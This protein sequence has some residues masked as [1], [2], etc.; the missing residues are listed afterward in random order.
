M[1]LP[2]ESSVGRNGAAASG[3]R[4]FWKF[5]VPMNGVEHPRLAPLLSVG[6]LETYAFASSSSRSAAACKALWQ[7]S[8]VVRSNITYVYMGP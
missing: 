8:A 4:N 5:T 3:N 1:C 7:M 6:L 2:R